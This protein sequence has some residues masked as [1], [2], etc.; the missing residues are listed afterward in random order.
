MSVRSRYLSSI[1]LAFC[2]YTDRCGL[3]VADEQAAASLLR[4]F[5]AQKKDLTGWP[6]SELEAYIEN[7]PSVES[8]TT[9]AIAECVKQF[10]TKYPPHQISVFLHEYLLALKQEGCSPATIRNYRSDINQFWSF[11]PKNSLEELLTKPIIASFVR[12]Q[13]QKQ[14][15]ASSIRRKFAA[16]CQFMLWANRQSLINADLQ[17]IGHQDSLEKLLERTATTVAPVILPDPT[18]TPIVTTQ[19]AI[20]YTDHERRYPLARRYQEQRAHL[21]DQLAQVSQKLRQRSQVYILPYLN[22]AFLCLFFLGLAVFGY[23][24][25]NRD[26]PSPLAYPSSPVTPN[27]V[28]SFQG[29][30]TDTAQNPLVTS[31]DMTFKLFNAGPGTGGTELWNSGTCAVDPDQDGIFSAGLGSDCGSPIGSSVFSENAN[32]WLEV[33]VEGETLA[34]RQPIQTVPYA[35]NSETVQGY[36]IT[37]SGAATVNTILTMNSAGEVVLGEVSPKIKSGSGTFTIEGSILLLQTTNN[38]NII[39]DA[40]G[41][42]STIIRDYLSAPGA[43][44]SATYAGATPLVVNGTGG[45]ILSLANNGN[46]TAAGTLTGLT[47]LSSSG[48]ITFSGL[49]NGLVRATSGV[50]SGGAT[51][52]L[53]S[54]VTGVLPI[55]NGG[56]NKNITLIPGAIFYADADTFE[57]TAAGTTSD[58]LLSGG[59]GAPTWGSCAG[60]VSSSILWHQV[61]GTSQLKN[62]TLD[63]LVGGAASSSAKFA[64]LNVNSGTPTASVSAGTAGGTYITADG[65]IQTTAN[66]NMTIGGNTTGNITLSPLSGS[67]T[68]TSTGSMNLSTGKDYQINGTSVL[69]NNTLGSGVT[70]SSLTTVGALST[71]TIASGFGTITTANTITGTTLNGTTGI[72]TGASAGTQ[73]IDASG[74]LVNIG[75]ITATGT[76]SQTGAS[77]LAGGVINLNTSSNNATNIGTGTT[78]STVA[79]GGGSNQV[80]I[81]SS[82][83]DI[84]GPG[85]AS[86]LTG[87]TSSG[88][89]TFSGLS[90]GIVKATSGVLS[91]GNSVS[92]TTDIT[93]VLPLANGGTNKNLT[94]VTGGI[95]YSDADSFEILA[96]GSSNECLLSGGAGAPT[97]GSCAG[98]VSGSIL[99]QQVA[100]TS[101]LKNTTLDLLVGGTSTASAKFAVLNVNNGTPTASVSAG[102]TGASYITA[103]GTIQTTAN[104]NMTIG[105]NTTGNITLSPLNGSGT[106]TSTGNVNLSTGKVYQINGTSVLSNNTLGSGVT[107]SSLTTVG[108]LSTGTI[109]S[110]FGTITTA[111]TITGTTL[112][113]TTG[114]NTGVSAGTQRIDASGNLVNIGNITATGTLSQTGASTLAGGVINLNASSNNAVNIGTG[115]TTSTVSIGGGSNQVAIDSSI[116]DISGPGVASGLTGLTSSG[117][118]TFSGLTANRFVKTTTGGLLTTSQYIDLTNEVT[119]VLPLANGG[120]NKNLTA[121]AGGIVYSD[122]D[123]FEI[124]AAGTASDCLLSGGTG[125]PTWGSCATGTT[126]YWQL[127]NTHNLSGIN[128]H[129]NILLGSTATASANIAINGDGSA[130]FNEQ[131]LDR[132][133]RV[134]GDTNANLFMI[135]AST[136]RIG[137]GTATPNARLDILA[138]SGDLLRL[139]YDTSNYKT[140]QVQSNGNLVMG[141]AGTLGNRFTFETAAGDSTLFLTQDTDD[142]NE[143]ASFKKTEFDFQ[144]YS[145]DEIGLIPGGGAGQTNDYLKISHSSNDIKLDFMNSDGSATIN[146]PSGGN[147]AIN[148]NTWDISGAGAATGLTGI[149]S[150]GNI[151]FSGLTANRFVKTTTGGLLTTSQYIDLAAD[152]TGVLPLAN[153]GSNKAL[154]AVA[155]G[156]VYTD[157]DSFEVLGAGTASNCLLSGGTGAPTWGSCATGATN[158]WQLNGTVLAPANA[159]HDLTIGGTATASAKVF[160]SGSTGNVSIGTTSNSNRLYVAQTDTRTSGFSSMVLNEYT[161]NPGSA[162]TATYIGTWNRAFSASGNAQ[163]ITGLRGMFNEAIHQGTSTVSSAHGVSSNVK[164]TNTGTINDAY[165]GYFE[166]QVTA[167]GTIVRGYGLYVANPTVSGGGA[168]TTNYGLYLAD[169]TNG[170]TDYAIVTNAGN[171]VFNEGGD[172][173]TDFRVEGDTNANLF[174][175]D[176]S[177]DRVGIGTNTPSSLLS[178]GSSSQFQVNTSGAI[179]AATGITSSGTITFSGLT[180]GIVKATSGVLSGGNSISL[181]ADVTGI[182]P[183]ANGGTNK[184]L[185]AAAGGIVYSDA[186]SFEILAAG[187]AS[188]CLI[189]GGA[190]APTWGSCSSAVASSVMWQQSAGTS[191]LKN[192]TLDLL[193]GGTSSVSAKFAVLNVNN[194]TPTASVSAGTAGASYITA[195]GTIQTTANQNLTIGGNTTGNITLSPLAGSGTVT[196]TGSMNLSTGKVYQIN[197]TSVLSN[198]TLGSGVTNSSLQTVGAL[199]SGS[200]VTG[201]GNITTTNLITGTTL[202]GTTGINTGASAGTQRIDN[203]GNL[204]NIGNVTA[205]G[206]FTQTGAT[207][208]SGG[209]VNINASSNFATNI[210][211]GTTTSTVTIGGGSNQVA[212]NSS[213]WGIS[214]VGVASGLTGLSSSGTITF[215]GL[216]ANRFVKTTTV[217]QLTT[218]QYIDLAGEV[219]GVLPLANGGSNKA[220]TA[221]AGGIVYSDADSFEIL[222]AGT[223][224]DCLISGGAGAPTWGTCGASNWQLNGTVLTPKNTTFDLAIGGISTSSAK[225]FVSG[226]SGNASSSGNLSFRGTSPKVNVLNGQSFGVQLSPGGDAGLTEYL[227]ILANGNVGVGT[228]TPTGLLHVTG[229]VTGKAL[230]IFNE[231]G[232]QD[233][234]TASASG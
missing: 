181:T 176:A 10:L 134:E 32:V 202:N 111:N 175:T 126:N 72:N 59:A 130:V 223:S 86:G 142:G 8:S 101:Q 13:R 113:G 183:L 212:I 46:I 132:D 182:L 89:I 147:L 29:R 62:T 38:G 143:Y 174:F 60:A 51:V 28:L 205:T 128:Q 158:Y 222:A 22:L 224:N 12:Y 95:V 137:V 123:S 226:T 141:G 5:V 200:I 56:T 68:V 92:L 1:S 195:D 153:G 99:W 110:G 70:T 194:G 49:A 196:S 177:A 33:G 229:A 162:S 90:D 24:Q 186:D 23:Q 207:T 42:G 188:D 151:T 73:R 58:C 139:G 166:N 48:S 3:S 93:G 168:I 198:N 77:T 219:T 185:T 76:L 135:D 138:T 63:L 172:A 164:L 96:A 104:Q 21:K 161:G 160:I 26:V 66:Q 221:A 67:G 9:T 47:G 119:G 179:A 170:A 234:I 156:L 201:F 115:T 83:W 124:L 4:N 208:L 215:S 20:T 122:A 94:A 41:S 43:T 184:A 61:A 57:M 127:N 71:G 227:T 225:F 102:T 173:D 118:I 17:W 84:S 75:N 178:V 91:G 88:T 191:Q 149:T 14:L 171:I 107:T 120:T 232:D 152:V 6:L 74:N 146:G 136:D 109:A 34:P 81:N 233:I 214:G 189:S 100:G 31:T 155:G 7:N 27:R 131:G 199:N 133:F 150:S 204:V 64:V 206:T 2:T 167:A 65:T 211:T 140:F 105:G 25:F 19:P 82:I 85:V 213:T 78:T 30:L 144:F 52:N 197:G 187:T 54:D 98:A 18:A 69:S 165:S 169:Q 125:A 216:T 97:W 129:Y 180:N 37:A 36:P 220:L 192:T 44:I 163:T 230:A 218:S 117:S 11:A 50:L 53:A 209:T 40:N 103:A 190:G 35:L 157:A 114:I 79:I 80:A 39:L 45:Q 159:T 121:I 116:W 112:N 217:G 231:I 145:D 228:A 203:S 15:Q 108:A 210:G 87:I 148:T 55:A 193:V 16:I 106:V 154:T